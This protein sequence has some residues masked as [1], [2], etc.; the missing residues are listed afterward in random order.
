MDLIC[1]V[2]GEPWEHDSLHEEAGARFTE[3]KGFDYKELMRREPDSDKRQRMYDPFWKAVSS[4]FRTKGCR[5]LEKGFGPQ[6]HCQPGA[7]DDGTRDKTFN[8]TRT[9]AASAL[10]DMLGD[11]MDGAAS[12]LDE[13]GF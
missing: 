10:Y 7:S 2:C 6:S 3:A 11:D 1:P 8:L 12:M 4:E 13:M 9:E 5:A